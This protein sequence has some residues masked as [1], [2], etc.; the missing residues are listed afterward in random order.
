MKAFKSLLFFLILSVMAIACSAQSSKVLPPKEFQTAMQN[1]GQ[2]ILLDVRTP[3]EYASG[4]IQ[5]AKNINVRNRSFNQEVA[6]LDIN[7]PVFVYCHSGGRSAYAASKLQSMGFLQVY[8]LRG[9]ITAWKSQGMMV[10]K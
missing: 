1:S 9:G 8:D 4:K 7:L 3:E 2:Y 6:Q 10:E 5:G